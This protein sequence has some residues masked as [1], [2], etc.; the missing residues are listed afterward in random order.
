MSL[1]SRINACG[2]SLVDKTIQL[3]STTFEPQNPNVSHLMTLDCSAVYQLHDKRELDTCKNEYCC[4]IISSL[5]LNNVGLTKLSKVL[6]YQNRFHNVHECII[7]VRKRTASFIETYNLNPK[8]AAE[9]YDQSLL[10]F[11]FVD[12]IGGYNRNDMVCFK[13]E[14]FFMGSKKNEY[15]VSFNKKSL[16]NPHD[17]V[18]K[19]N[20]N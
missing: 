9:S 11:D 10:V 14:E 16:C 19:Q 8:M 18:Y 7:C 12:K 1:Q 6:G 20:L 5:G 4:K 17:S 13:E 15:G 2:K 3:N